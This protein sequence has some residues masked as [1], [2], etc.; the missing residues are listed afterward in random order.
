MVS[1]KFESTQRVRVREI[2]EI[3]NP[4]KPVPLE[5]VMG[6]FGIVET[7]GRVYGTDADSAKCLIPAYFVR[8]DGIGPV[9]VGEEWLEDA[10]AE[11]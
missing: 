5:K 10:P 1:P 2:G 11:D 7:A 3:E 8:V 6:L 9:L 4:G